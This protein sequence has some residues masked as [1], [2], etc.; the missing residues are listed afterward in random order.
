[1]RNKIILVFV[2]DT[3][4]GSS[5][6]KKIEVRIQVELEYSEIVLPSLNTLV[7]TLKL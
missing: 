1:M 7:E 3:Y 4:I 2:Y 5:F 6:L